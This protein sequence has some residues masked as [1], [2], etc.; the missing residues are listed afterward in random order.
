MAG[1]ISEAV[2]MTLWMMALILA[3]GGSMFAIYP[4]ALSH[5][6][7]F[8]ERQD[9]VAASGGLIMFYSIGATLGPTVAGVVMETAGTYS[10]FAFMAA[11]GVALALFA[12]YRLKV[13]QA[14]AVEDKTPF[15][16]TPRT[17]LAVTALDP[18]AEEDQY[19][20]DFSFGEEPTE[21][22]TED[23]QEAA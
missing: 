18:R 22:P 15:Q 17:T 8:I 4:L 9:F 14:V 11:S 2:P 5:A 7:D 16:I 23:Q 12:L 6:N 13:S 3:F 21:E 19:S 10:L 1:A 20:F